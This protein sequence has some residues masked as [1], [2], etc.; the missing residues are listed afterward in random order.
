MHVRL[1]IKTLDFA[2]V[3]RYLEGVRQ[4]ADEGARSLDPRVTLLALK[5][6]QMQDATIRSMLRRIA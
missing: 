3:R 2:E 6:L 1:K 5:V 4:L